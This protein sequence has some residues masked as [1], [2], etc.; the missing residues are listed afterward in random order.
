MIQ[1]FAGASCTC[2]SALRRLDFKWSLLVAMIFLDTVWL[3]AKGW[4]IQQSSL[5][6]SIFLATSFLAPLSIKRY[7]RDDIIFTLCEAVIYSLFLAEAS[8]ILSYLVVSTNFNLVDQSLARFDEFLG[9]NWGDYYRWA[10]S[11]HTYYHVIRAAYESLAAQT[12]LVIIYLCFTKRTTR[13]REFLELSASLIAASILLSLFFPA[14]GA[15][16]FYA[17]TVHADVSAWSHFEA[18]RSG[19]MNIIDLNSMQGLVSIPSVHT[20]MAILFCW[21]VRRTPI[22]VVIIPLNLAL[23]LSTP[24]VGGHYITDVLTGGVLTFAA[25]TL[26][27]VILLR[28][29]G[30]RDRDGISGTRHIA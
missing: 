29:S 2:T 15:A 4:S 28:Q 6:G 20:V 17:E 8:A 3:L 14:E 13:V 9:F 26:R 25:I 12:W 11:H 22:A 24:V 19:S 18:L 1:T 5:Y 7:R 16:K 21:A 30:V 10:V 27:Q 23:L